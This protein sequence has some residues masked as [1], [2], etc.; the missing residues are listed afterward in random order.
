MKKRYPYYLK[1]RAKVLKAQGDSVRVIADALGVGKSAVGDWVCGMHEEPAMLKYCAKCGDA[2][3]AC[4]SD[5]TRCPS[6]CT[7]V[8]IKRPRVPRWCKLCGILIERQGPAKFCCVEHKEVFY[9]QRT[10]RWCE[11]KF[12]AYPASLRYCCQEHREL[13]H[14]GPPLSNVLRW[15][16]SCGVRFVPQHGNQKFCC[17]SHRTLEYQNVGGDERELVAA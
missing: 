9:R 7:Q 13:A 16:P 6:R 14:K 12:I 2:F 3:L 8:R 10:C 5:S 17:P 4:R 11:K 15:C 1:E